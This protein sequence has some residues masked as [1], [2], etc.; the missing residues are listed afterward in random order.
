MYTNNF[1]KVHKAVVVLII[2]IIS[3]GIFSLIDLN[4]INPVTFTLA[5]VLVMILLYPN[6]IT[7]DFRDPFFN[8]W[9]AFGVLL[10]AEVL[11][12]WL[13]FGEPLGTA[14]R[15][16]VYLFPYVL[17]L[18]IR[19]IL[20]YGDNY[21]YV[22]RGLIW[23]GVFAC[24]LSYLLYFN[25][26]SFGLL[27][28]ETGT[29]DGEFT[30]LFCYLMIIL[31]TWLVISEIFDGEWSRKKTGWLFVLTFLLSNFIIV[32]R[33]RAQAIG[34]L[35]ACVVTFLCARDIK[36]WKKVVIIFI[37]VIAVT[38][39]DNPLLQMLL[40]AQNQ[41]ATGTSTVAIRTEA[42]SYFFSEWTKHPLFGFGGI[43][44]VTPYKT[45]YTSLF[46]YYTSDVGIVGWLYKYGLAGIAFYI[47]YI[48]IIVKCCLTRVNEDRKLNYFAIAYLGYRLTTVFTMINLDYSY[49][50]ML[51][52]DIF[53][54]ALMSTFYLKNN[55]ESDVVNIEDS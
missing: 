32:M 39:I 18:P 44:L 40:T 50:G 27:S 43:S 41:V 51:Y 53:A 9:I 28:G 12:S 8:F 16:L 30:V 29:R 2:W 15:Q 49:S 4:S 38:S 31:S 25:D 47:Y 5:S 22:K 10:M 48:Y 17:Y 1:G 20:L 37:A 33:Y 46:S 45:D 3:Q 13:T 23:L 35:A 14:V 36:L 6:V 52:I 19:N 42:Y 11:Q 54:F 34:I 7:I 55:E 26:G 24:A 21:D